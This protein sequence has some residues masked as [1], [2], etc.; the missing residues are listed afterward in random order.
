[1][2][3]YDVAVVGGGPTGATSALFT[4][5]YG[6]ET[7]VFDRGPSSIARCGHLEN[8]PGFPGGIDVETYSA[9]LAAQLEHAGVTLEEDLVEHVE[10]G[11]GGNGFEV[12]PQSGAPVTADRVVAASR[13]DADYLAPLCGGDAFETVE[14]HGEDHRQFDRDYPHDDG[15]TVFSGLY[16]ASPSDAADR[17][18]VM[19]AGRGAT[20]AHAV[21]E[22]VRMETGLSGELSDCRD[23]V[24]R[25]S[26]LDEEWTGREPW[27]EWF[28][29]QFP[30]DADLGDDDRVMLR[31]AEVDRLL[32]ACLSEDE[33]DRRR[34]AGQ[35]LLVEHLDDDVVLE[36]ARAIERER[37]ATSPTSEGG[38]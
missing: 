11:P 35:E 22:D 4:E 1:M 30:A 18:A 12:T 36:R 24:R 34:R 9:L 2:T 19:A 14:H 3:D 29:E 23:W 26:D 6:L 28:A 27:R 38:D 33:I 13:Y 25:L 8:Y 31:E 15:R 16:V 21:L 20:V 5:R 10:R 7:V 17:Q 32:D 37:T